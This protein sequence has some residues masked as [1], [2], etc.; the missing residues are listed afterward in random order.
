MAAGNR[1]WTVVCLAGPSSE[2]LRPTIERKEG[3][4]G[5]IQGD[6][7]DSK[8]AKRMTRPSSRGGADLQ[9]TMSTGLKQS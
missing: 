6:Q 8:H 5:D 7:A 9:S 2:E 1:Q 3:L 4:Q